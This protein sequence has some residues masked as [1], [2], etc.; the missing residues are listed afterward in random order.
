MFSLHSDKNLE[1]SPII[2]KSN[3]Y[4]LKSNYTDYKHMYTDCS[5]DSIKV[6]CA[7]VSDNYSENM[8][9]LDGISIFTTE[10]NAIDLS[11]DFIANCKISNKFITFLALLSVLKSLYH[12]SSKIYKFENLLNP[13]INTKYSVPITYYY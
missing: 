6:G 5:K 9:I 2:M 4:E 13:K 11:L 1:T 12:T 7:V 3:V 10:A 8:R